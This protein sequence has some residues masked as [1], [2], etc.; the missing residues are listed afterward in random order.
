MFHY[1]RFIRY[2]RTLSV[3]TCLFCITLPVVSPL[4]GLS[5]DST[6]PSITILSSLGIPGGLA[7][8]V[9]SGN[10]DFIS[11]LAKSGRFIAQVLV[12][13]T[14]SINSVRKTLAEQNIQGQA[15]AILVNKNNT[16]PFAENIV[17]IVIV[18]DAVCRIQDNEI[19]RVLAPRGIVLFNK[20]TATH[21]SLK[22]SMQSL[23]PVSI[24]GS[25]YTC[26]MKSFPPEMDEWTHHRH[27][28]SANALS[29]DTIAG[30]PRRIRWLA[31]PWQEVST[32]ITAAGRIHYGGILTRDAFNGLRLW[33]KTLKP[34]P[35]AG[36]FG[37]G[38][39]GGSV[40]AIAGENK[41]FVYTEGK[42]QSI[43]SATGQLVLEYAGIEQ[44]RELLYDNGRLVVICQNAVQALDAKTGTLKWRFEASDPR[45]AVMG[46][47]IVGFIQ[48]NV[49]RGEQ[50]EAV[51][52]EADTGKVRWKNG[53][54]PWVTNVT[55]CLYGNDRLVYEISSLNDNAPNNSIHV[56]S[57]KDGK[58]LFDH[59]YAPGSNH[60]RQS[61]ATV[62][63]ERIW[64]LQGGKITP[65]E[66]QPIKIAA[67]DSTS[68]FLMTTLDAGLTHCFPPIATK[69]FYISGEM[70]FTDFQTGEF[71]ANHITK[72]ACGRDSGW[73]P[74]NGLIY[75]APKHCV[76][77]PMVRGYTAMASERPCG[78]LVA[79][80]I[81]EISFNPEK[82]AE[83]PS[84][85][86]ENKNTD[87]PCY[88]SD[89]WRSSSTASIGPKKLNTLWTTDL[90]KTGMPAPI[91]I[92]WTENPFSKGSITAPVS[93]N[94]K[95]FVARPDAHQVVALDA[96]TGKECWRFTAEGR[97]D[98]APTIHRGLCIFGSRSGDVYCLNANDGKMV[99]H[100]RAAPSDENIVTYGQVE[101]PWPVPGS[102]IVIDNVAYFAA[103]RQSL[104]D[105]GILIFAVDPA[106]GKKDW[107][108]RLDSIPQKGF[109]E[110]SGLEFDNFDIL[111]Q[112]DDCIAMSRWLFKRTDGSMSVN[113]LKSFAKINTGNGEVWA[114]KGCWSY[115]PR[116]RPRT[117]EYTP[118]R[119]LTAFRDNTIIGCLQGMKTLFRRDFNAEDIAAFNPMWMTGWAAQEVEGKK[120]KAPEPERKNMPSPWRTNRLAE[121]STWQIEPFGENKENRTVNALALAGD[122]FYT[123]DSNGEI[124]ARSTSDG[125]LIASCKVPEP[126]WDGIA[127]ANGRLIVSTTDGK[128][129]CLGE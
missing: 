109:Y 129:F 56:V 95:V 103:G 29:G 93:A 77:W 39:A 76:C 8:Q 51:N 31:G 58:L 61:R 67:L 59:V 44:P 82:G 63:G 18:T 75:A 32:M 12:P 38:R 37:F 34:S 3:I 50:V 21:E 78:D 23:P 2:S 97:V 45:A 33:D 17:N 5:E 65:E 110:S 128:V 19:L 52:L 69:R 66:R 102:V 74:A 68:G 25:E 72:A 127:V 60:M 41:L 112:E 27:S 30:I 117:R 106:T 113:K 46:D 73:V 111:Q 43:D 15:S 28:A 26:F 64:I 100:L 85:T 35:A 49:K 11:E 91:G 107:V 55:D 119:P 89:P 57:A 84:S 114:P 53:D 101:S 121:K 125:Q 54:Y 16:L 118:N 81:N 86:Y 10:T 42:I 22:S 94:G 4:T 6:T 99:W 104:A 115:A 9:G 20:G 88:R 79:K 7:V 123:A 1:R 92:D 71:S 83:P 70:N 47:N 124:Q 122:S 62:I 116:H 40:P 24:C 105:G 126:L 90:G 14:A 120:L 87:W 13:D 80:N 108:Q 48:G 96:N 98:T 36:N